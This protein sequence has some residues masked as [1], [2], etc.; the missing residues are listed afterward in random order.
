MNGQL[1]PH[2]SKPMMCSVLLAAR[3]PAETEFMQCTVRHQNLSID[4]TK[5]CNKNGSTVYKAQTTLHRL[6]NNCVKNL[7]NLLF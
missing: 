5:T 4:K 3:L 1:E 6:Q 7:Q 2:H